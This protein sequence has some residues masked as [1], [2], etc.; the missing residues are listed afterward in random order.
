[1]A[2]FKR[3]LKSGGHVWAYWFDAP[4]STRENRK[5]ITASGFASKKAAQDAEAE[6]RMQAQRDAELQTATPG[7][8]PGTLESLLKEF[9]SEHGAKSLAP[10]T[11]DRYQDMA[12]YLDADLKAMQLPA[13]KPLHLSREWNRLLNSGGR[14]RKAGKP[15]SRKT[16]RNIAGLVSSAYT[17]GMRWGIVETNP[18]QASEPPVPK[19][20]EALALTT[21]QTELIIGAANAPW[22]LE[23]FLELD[24]ATGARRGELL[25]LRW[26]DL[27]G[28]QLMISRSL[29]QVGQ[30]VFLKEPKGKKVR[31]ITIPESALKKLE[32]HRVR[33]AEYRQHF[34][35][36]YQDDFIFCNPDGTPLKPDTISA[37]VSLLFRTLKLPK[38]ASLHTLR[39]T[40]ASH[41]LAAG[42]P[43]TDV[44][45]RLGHA[46]A[47][48]TATVYAHALP[49]RDDLAAKAWENFQ[50]KSRTLAST[51]DSSILSENGP[52]SFSLQRKQ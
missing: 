4:G 7:A 32:A 40:H 51:S 15:L 39:H 41:L 9:F 37:S 47:H 27:A 42:V 5:Q 25:G 44:S 6:R 24:A 18:V 19:K 31:P 26:S 35:D 11:L 22:G 49:G 17:R 30:S 46:N 48:V 20:K 14:G 43:L 34:G 2:I 16:V 28:D 52:A 29:S 21:Q 12:E 13:I 10:K 33:Q 45:R 1:M 3:K 50:T 36:A 23:A 8:V 38:G